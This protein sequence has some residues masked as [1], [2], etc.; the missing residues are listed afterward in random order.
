MELALK[1]LQE[2]KIENEHY[3]EKILK[4]L[5]YIETQDVSLP[6]RVHY[7]QNLTKL[8][9]M[10][11]PIDFSETKK[12]NIELVILQNNRLIAGHRWEYWK[13]TEMIEAQ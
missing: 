10:L 7:L 4:F 9:R 3:K 12:E 6:R 5:D 8:A 2:S 1:K 11:D 13:G